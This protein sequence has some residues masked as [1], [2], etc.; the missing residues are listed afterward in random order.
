[1]KAQED[2]E[3]LRARIELELQ[4]ERRQN[5]ILTEELARQTR[6]LEQGQSTRKAD[7]ELLRNLQSECA[8]LRA[9]RA[10]A[11]RLHP[12]GSGARYY[13][14]LESEVTGVLRRLGLRSRA[15]DWQGRELVRG[16][17]SRR[18]RSTG[19]AECSSVAWFR[20]GI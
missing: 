19:S 18:R 5:R 6:A 17:P 4:E 15:E 1:M 7:E 9:Q 13:A 11:E 2:V 16:S 20:A 12:L 10:E 14:H 8:E 3:L